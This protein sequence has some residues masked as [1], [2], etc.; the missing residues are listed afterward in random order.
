MSPEP[1]LLADAEE[2]VLLAGVRACDVDCLQELYRRHADA[3]LG[4]AF[5]LVPDREAAERIATEAFLY[6]W[7]HVEALAAPGISVRS[8]LLEQTR[9]ASSSGV[10]L[11]LSGV[12]PGGSDGQAQEAG[13]TPSLDDAGLHEDERRALELALQGAN[14][15]EIAELLGAHPD[16]VMAWLST[17]LKKLSD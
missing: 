14:Y 12:G 13:G 5:Q 15:K 2:A 17:G 10:G 7:D 16:V 6:L 1:P 4:L 9:R 8:F 3:V 11:Q